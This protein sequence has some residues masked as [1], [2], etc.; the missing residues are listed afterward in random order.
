[1]FSVNDWARGP[2]AALPI[3][4]SLRQK[5]WRDKKRAERDEKR[6][7]ERRR[8]VGRER[9]R[10]RKSGARSAAPK[11]GGARFL[12]L[13]Q[14]KTGLW[15]SFRGYLENVPFLSLV[16]S[17]G[18]LFRARSDLRFYGSTVLRLRAIETLSQ[19][20]T[21]AERGARLWSF[22][23]LGSEVGNSRN[24]SSFDDQKCQKTYVC[25]NRN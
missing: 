24:R 10:E 8:E 21:F 17:A 12:G 2:I 20:S 25:K 9:E 19:L 16:I 22:S 7:W 4:A 14:S 5:R 13:C 11:R 3:E 18:A 6:K 15:N 1:M 23:F